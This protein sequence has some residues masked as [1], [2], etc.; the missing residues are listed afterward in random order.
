[1]QAAKLLHRAGLKD[2]RAAFLRALMKTA[3]TPQDYTLVSDFAVSMGQL[4]IAVKVAKEAEKNGI[5]LIDYAFPTIMHT[6]DN[7]SS[8]DKALVHALIRQESQFDPNAVSASGALG[9]MQIMPATGKHTA[10]REG[11]VHNTAWL[12][13]KPEHNVG[14][15]GS[16]AT[17]TG[18]TRGR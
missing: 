18:G 4:D 9:L 3:D 7:A 11:V 10:K 2:E 16:S 6:M 1:M 8:T 13:S 15:M 14:D 5:Y 12:T 17:T